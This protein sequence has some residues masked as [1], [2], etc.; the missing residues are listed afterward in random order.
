VSQAT[1]NMRERQARIASAIASPGDQIVLIGDVSTSRTGIEFSLENR[2]TQT[3]NYGA[4]WDLAY[5]TNGTWRPVSDRPVSGGIAWILIGHW[6]QSGGIQQ[7]QI[8][9]SWRFGELPPGRYMYIR[10]GWLG[11]DWNPDSVYALVEFTI[12]ADC[13]T[14][15]P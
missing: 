12:T 14:Y 1:Q 15:L 3:F 11:E 6:L 7:Y 5:Y 9:W 2:T 8:N 13:H 4:A 10:G